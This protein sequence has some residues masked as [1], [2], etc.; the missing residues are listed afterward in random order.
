MQPMKLHN[1]PLDG[2]ATYKLDSHDILYNNMRFHIHQWIPENA[3]PTA[4]LM[5]NGQLVVTFAI[6]EKCKCTQHCERIASARCPRR[7]RRLR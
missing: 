2:V 3:E 5:A 4:E 6:G 7:P 1:G